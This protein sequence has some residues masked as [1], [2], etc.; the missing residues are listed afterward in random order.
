MS[1]ILPTA[2]MPAGLESKIGSASSLVEIN[3]ATSVPA[4]TSPP[5]KSEAQA[6]EKPHCGRSPSAAPTGGPKRPAFCIK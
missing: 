2:P 5:L 1:M 6:A 4:D 3:T